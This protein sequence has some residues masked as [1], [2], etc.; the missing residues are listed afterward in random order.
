MSL[1]AS[2]SALPDDRARDSYLSNLWKTF[3]HTEQFEHLLTLLKEL[4]SKG[5]SV[6]LSPSAAAD[7]R[8]FA[9]GIL[10]AIRTQANWIQAAIF[11]DPATAQYAP[12]DSSSPADEDDVP[13]PEPAY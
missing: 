12:L 10:S 4:H 2:L 11:F 6:I 3:Q 5:E 8:A 1:A 13:V 7:E 9:S